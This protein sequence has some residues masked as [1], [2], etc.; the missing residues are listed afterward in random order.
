MTFDIEIGE[1]ASGEVASAAGVVARGMRDNAGHVAVFGHNAARRSRALQSMFAG[2]LP[3]MPPPIVARRRGWI[4]GVCG[5]ISPDEPHFVSLRCVVRMAPRAVLAPV[6]SMRGAVW[7]RTWQNVHPRE[8][9]WHLGPVAVD[10]PLQHLGIGSRMLS[11]FCE[12]VDASGMPAYL[13]TDKPEN[14]VFY[15]RFGFEVMDERPALGVNNWFM[16]RS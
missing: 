7:M 12:R 10:A 15:E 6:A 5:L 1:L 11:A 16:W 8:P 9:H 13:E 2:V 3:T 4:V 14:V